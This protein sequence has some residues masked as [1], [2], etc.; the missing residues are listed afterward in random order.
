VTFEILPFQIDSI[1]SGGSGTYDIC[2]ITLD[3]NTP[4]GEIVYFDM[5]ITAHNGYLTQNPFTLVTGLVIE[6]FESGNFDELDWTFSGDA[7]WIID[8]NSYEG[9][10]SAQSGSISNNNESSLEITMDVT[11]YSDI[12]FWK[13][14]SS[15][16]DYD[17]LRFYIDDELE[18]EWSG[19]DDWSEVTYEVIPG[20]RTF[21]WTYYKD[22]GVSTGDD[23]GWIDYIVFPA[24]DMG[25][26]SENPIVQTSTKLLGNY[27]NPFNPST[28]ISFELNPN[29]QNPELIIYNLKG[30][31]VKIFPVIPS[32]AQ[33]PGQ[34]SVTWNGTDDAGKHV[35]S[36]IYF[37][38]LKT[39]STQQTRKM[40]LMK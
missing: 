5:D 38:K 26:D 15:E 16:A 13:K 8:T 37:Y 20:M 29:D 9:S 32:G 1:N 12:S 27:P 39:S 28:T 34:H 2:N 24:V 22:Q 31:K 11:A 18:D 3:E 4:L 35:S 7:D 40:I 6:D 23:C 10:Y 30:Q 19:E 14:V 17:Y 36:G 25:T 21:K 33:G